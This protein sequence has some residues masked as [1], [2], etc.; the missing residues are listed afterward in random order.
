ME[1]IFVCFVYE[2]IIFLCNSRL[3][4]VRDIVHSLTVCVHKI[5]R[6]YIAHSS[7]IIAIDILLVWHVVNQF[8]SLF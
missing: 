3:T 8:F 7:N 1:N 4:A 6:D 2:N 5:A